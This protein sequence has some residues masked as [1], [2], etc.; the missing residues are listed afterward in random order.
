[1]GPQIESPAL[2]SLHYD[3]AP[4]LLT[5]RDAGSGVAT[6]LESVRAFCILKKHIK[7]ILLSYFRMQK[8]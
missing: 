6:I 1:M 8:N 4:F 7:M 3:S 2:L 5:W